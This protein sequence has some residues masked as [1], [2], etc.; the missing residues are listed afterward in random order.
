MYIEGYLQNL[1][2]MHEIQKNRFIVIQNVN[3]LCFNIFDHEKM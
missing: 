1:Q 2:K 3:K